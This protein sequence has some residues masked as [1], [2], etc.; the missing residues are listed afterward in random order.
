MN[1]A[2]IV[3]LAQLLFSSG[4]LRAPT[5]T[6]RPRTGRSSST[7]LY[8]FPQA[9]FAAGCA[10]AVIAYVY[11][12]IDSIKEQQRVAIDKAMSEQATSIKSAQDQQRQ[13]I[14]KAQREQA[15]AIRKIREMRK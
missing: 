13:A 9:V 11:F 12:N 15:E 1:L 7:E 5:S 3:L 10:G 14:E 6:W 8:I 4:F 2:L